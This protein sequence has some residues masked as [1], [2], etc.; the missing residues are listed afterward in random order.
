M[1]DQ[2]ELSPREAARQLEVGL[3]H[4]YQSLWVGKLPGRKVGVHWRIPASA[5]EARLKAREA[6]HGTGTARG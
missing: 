3:Q 5:I 2:R 4:V 1:K 6:E